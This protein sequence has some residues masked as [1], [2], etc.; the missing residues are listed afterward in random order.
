MGKCGGASYSLV[1]TWGVDQRAA[2][3][4]AAWRVVQ[5]LHLDQNIT[6]S[7]FETNIRVVGGLLSAHTLMVMDLVDNAR[8]TRGSGACYPDFVHTW[9]PDRHLRE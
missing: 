2:F 7:V 4:A 3:H 8:P 5:G 9:W 6:V 1:L